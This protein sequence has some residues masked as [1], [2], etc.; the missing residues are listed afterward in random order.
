MEQIEAKKSKV[1]P[2]R[3]P[4]RP[5]VRKV[6]TARVTPTVQPIPNR[7]PFD[8]PSPTIFCQRTHMES[9][10][11]C[12]YLFT[13]EGI[14]WNNK[15]LPV[16]FVTPTPRAP[17]TPTESPFPTLPNSLV[18]T[19]PSTPEIEMVLNDYF[20]QSNSREQSPIPEQDVEFVL[21]SLFEQQAARHPQRENNFPF[22]FLNPAESA[23]GA[24]LPEDLWDL[25]N[26]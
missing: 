14:E 11:C 13:N 24:D 3:P 6:P 2:Q 8:P 15:R 19:R 1:L 25:F 22:L 21:D 16:C 4:R 12:S 10:S 9:C 23:P 17:P 18:E 26:N 20:S 5:K 7:N